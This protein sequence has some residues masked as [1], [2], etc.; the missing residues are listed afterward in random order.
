MSVRLPCLAVFDYVT[1]IIRSKDNVIMFAD[2][3]FV[4]GAR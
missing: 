4:A 1:V 2:S 3:D